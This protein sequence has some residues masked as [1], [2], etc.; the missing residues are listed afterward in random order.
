MRSQGLTGASSCGPR[1]Q[2]WKQ[3]SSVTPVPFRE[4]SSPEEEQI[5]W[6]NQDVSYVHIKSEMPLSH[7]SEG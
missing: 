3:G 4:T 2:K 1:G 6:G 7:P 5:W